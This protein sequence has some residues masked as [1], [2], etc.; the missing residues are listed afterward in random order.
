MFNNK[1]V[2]QRKTAGIKKVNTKTINN[3]HKKVSN[4]RSKTVIKVS[5]L[6]H[7]SPVSPKKSNLASF[8]TKS[9][10]IENSNSRQNSTNAIYDRKKD[11]IT[12]LYDKYQNLNKKLHNISRYQKSTKKEQYLTPMPRTHNIYNSHLE[13]R[14]MNNAIS[15]AILLRRL[16]YNKHILLEKNKKNKRNKIIIPPRKTSETSKSSIR[17][18]YD[19]C[20]II[21]IQKMCKGFLAR[22]VDK[23]IMRMKARVCLVETFCLLLGKNFNKAKKK[24]VF[25]RLKKLYHIPFNK[26]GIELSFKDRLRI[27]LINK[28]YNFIEKINCEISAKK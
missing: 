10:T 3:H 1:N 6:K 27:L 14:L 23:N 4:I 28:Y 12:I 2:N 21:T 8:N 15:N 25:S 26:I 22:R 16:E 24:I 18:T 13:K 17:K 11:Y 5:T 9:S 7:N 20:K 19:V